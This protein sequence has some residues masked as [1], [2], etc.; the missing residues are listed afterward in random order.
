[1]KVPNRQLPKARAG[2]FSPASILPNAC[3]PA[4]TPAPPWLESG[5]WPARWR[6]RRIGQQGVHAASVRATIFRELSSADAGGCQ[7]E[8][9][10]TDEI[11]VRD[12]PWGSKIRARRHEPSQ[13]QREE[14]R[15]KRSRRRR[16]LEFPHGRR[17]RSAH[18]R[19]ARKEVNRSRAGDPRLMRMDDE[20]IHRSDCERTREPG[21]DFRDSRAA[22]P[23]G[24]STDHPDRRATDDSDRGGSTTDAHFFKISGAE[25]IAHGAGNSRGILDADR[26]GRFRDTQCPSGC[27]SGT[28]P[29]AV[30]LIELHHALVRAGIDGFAPPIEH[31]VLRLDHFGQIAAHEDDPIVQVVGQIGEE[32]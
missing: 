20:A 10:T 19:P 28:G 14:R 23:F 22:Y 21:G 6:R 1:V 2:R 17:R 29:C 24:S 12:R 25:K 9:H 3:R 16:R 7:G 30:P 5:Q 4:G 15:R 31:L 26:G 27:A 18:C 11:G 13:R 32:E 8:D